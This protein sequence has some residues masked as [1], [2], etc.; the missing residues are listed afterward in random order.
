MTPEELAES[1]NKLSVETTGLISAE[2]TKATPEDQAII[3][4]LDGRKNMNN[5][6]G[7]ITG[8]IVGGYAPI[9]MYR[10]NLTKFWD[11]ENRVGRFN[12]LGFRPRLAFYLLGSA[13]GVA[14]CA[15]FGS[16]TAGYFDRKSSVEADKQYPEVKARSDVLLANISII[17][18]KYRQKRD[19]LRLKYLEEGGDPN[20]LLG[21]DDASGI[22][23]LRQ[24]INLLY[25]I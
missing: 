24:I 1:S 23:V 17:T 19:E 11:L 25:R 9:H 14:T 3:R 18:I 2:L 4:N 8:G 20:V 5:Y 10:R 13:L 7:L 15:A 22:S 16:H 12:A 6:A 21:S